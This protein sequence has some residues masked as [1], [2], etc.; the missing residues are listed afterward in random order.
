MLD[1]IKESAEHEMQKIVVSYQ[2]ELTKLRT[3]RAHTGLVDSVKVNYHGSEVPLKNVANISVSDA[4]TLTITPWE[5]ELV[6]TIEK[7][8]M[9]ADLGLSPVS[10]ANLVRIP[11]P[12]LTEERRRE[13]GKM[14]RNV[15]ESSKVAVRNARRNA[16]DNVKDLVKR[17]EVN[18]DTEHR[19]QDLIQ[20]I[21]DKFI[22]Q[23]DQLADAKE[24]ELLQI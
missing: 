11:I 9:L 18:T 19:L 21:T 7:A 16:M 10:E 24:K 6:K 20:K 22:A 12:V 2:G 4:R 8:V 23:I 17:K 13:L 15:A 1:K 5:K 3:G 14:V